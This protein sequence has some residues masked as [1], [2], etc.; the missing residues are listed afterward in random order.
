MEE[1]IG[2]QESC[3]RYSSD[4]WFFCCPENAGTVPRRVHRSATQCGWIHCGTATDQ[5]TDQITNTNRQDQMTRWKDNTF[6]D[7]FC[8]GKHNALHRIPPL[9]SC[10]QRRPELLWQQFHGPQSEKD[11]SQKTLAHHAASV[12]GRNIRGFKSVTRGVGYLLYL[13]NIGFGVQCICTDEELTKQKD[14]Y[15]GR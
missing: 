15:K 7:L 12:C 13:R 11:T 2:Q 6:C 5:P 3:A 14:L 4:I 1:I 8:R 9:C 10:S